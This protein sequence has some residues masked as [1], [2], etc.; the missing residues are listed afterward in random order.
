LCSG[1]GKEGKG[2]EWRTRCIL[3]AGEG[4]GEEGGTARLAVAARRT[5]TTEGESR[6]EVTGGGRWRRM[7]G[8]LAYIGPAEKQRAYG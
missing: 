4:P 5:A 3:V 1:K 7:G 6:E 2:R 8:D